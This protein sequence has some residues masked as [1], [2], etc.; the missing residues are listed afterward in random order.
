MIKNNR[1]KEGL[2]IITPLISAHETL[3]DLKVFDSSSNAMLDLDGD[4]LAGVIV[5]WLLAP[6]ANLGMAACNLVGGHHGSPLVLNFD[7]SGFALSNAQ[8]MVLARRAIGYLFF[9]PITAASLVLAILRLADP[10]PQQAMADILFDPLLI[11]YS[12][13]LAE[14][15]QTKTKDEGDPAQLLI[16]NLLARLTVYMEGLHKAGRIKEL[17]PSERERLIEGHRQHESMWQTRKDAQK[18]SILMSLAT[19]SVLLYGNRS[20]SYFKGPDGNTQRNEMKMHSMSHSFEMPR[21][22]ILESFDLDYTL[23][24]FRATRLA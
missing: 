21:L 5:G 20:I 12:G 22:D 2:D 4:E 24:V 18:S 8:A 14:W 23:R 6:N 15:L 13:S 19:R 10:E 1:A 17:R 3:C 11:S 9:H 7:A 16:E